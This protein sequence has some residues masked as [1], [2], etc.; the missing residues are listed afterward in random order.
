M[1]TQCHN[2][3][4]GISCFYPF[5][6]NIR[7]KIRFIFQT[8]SVVWLFGH[9]PSVRFFGLKH[10]CNKMNQVGQFCLPSSTCNFSLPQVAVVARKAL[11]F[12]FSF[13]FSLILFFIHGCHPKV[14]LSVQCL[15]FNEQVLPIFFPKIS[16]HFFFYFFFLLF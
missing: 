11:R 5:P 4:Y 16:F 14:L 6:L 12:S 2:E 9:H 15:S 13:F 10:L 8:W 7:K 3:F 1:C